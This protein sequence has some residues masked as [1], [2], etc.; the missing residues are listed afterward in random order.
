MAQ[1]TAEPD[2]RFLAAL[3]YT[4]VF[5]IACYA[6]VGM[7]LASAALTGEH[8]TPRQVLLS[9]LVAGML[10]CF[11]SFITWRTALLITDNLSLNGLLYLNGPNSLAF[12]WATGLVSV[13]S[14]SHLAA[15]AALALSANIAANLPDPRPL[16]RRL[17]PQKAAR[18]NHRQD[19]TAG[20]TPCS[21]A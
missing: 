15:G 9:L 19:P 2:V 1:G 12:L 5:T 20:E 10:S 8:M 3:A 11:L 4:L 17:Q 16:L 7:S 14:P 21:A 13:A 6:S 18:Y